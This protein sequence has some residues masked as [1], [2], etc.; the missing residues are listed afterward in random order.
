MAR[1]AGV[2]IPENKH[3]EISLTHIYGIGRVTAQKICIELNI[4]FTKKISELSEDEIEKIR[5]AVGSYQVEGD[6]RRNISTNIKRLMDLGSYRGIR[7]RRKLPTR[8]QN[9]K[10]NARTRKGP[11]KPMRG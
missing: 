3:V 11:K 5:S 7:H 2:N 9:T 8:G 6:L 10:N 4:D 1:I